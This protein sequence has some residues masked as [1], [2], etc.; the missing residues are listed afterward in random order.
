MTS[1]YG[2][3]L[4]ERAENPY[5]ESSLVPISVVPSSHTNAISGVGIVCLVV[6]WVAVFARYWNRA[7]IMRFWGYDDVFM[8]LTI[9]SA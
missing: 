5:D 8:L 1:L 6:S 3:R 9:V 2:S 4:L 7:V